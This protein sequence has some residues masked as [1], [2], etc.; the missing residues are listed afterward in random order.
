MIYPK[1][2]PKREDV[3]IAVM[4]KLL[5][6]EL[7]IAWGLVN[8]EDAADESKFLEAYARCYEI[9]ESTGTIVKRYIKNNEY[10]GVSVAEKNKFF[11]LVKTKPK[12]TD[13]LWRTVEVDLIFIVDLQ[14]LKPEVAHR[15]DYEV[16]ADVEE[17]VSTVPNV[18]VISQLLGYE[19]ALKGIKYEQKNDYSE[20]CVFGLKLGISYSIGSEINCLT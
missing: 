15:A 1:E 18:W 17:L 13:R 19:E 11:F 9:K 5:H 6:T 20:Y 8:A 12:N 3:A 4:Q 10:E 16:L 2:N 14:K 7:N